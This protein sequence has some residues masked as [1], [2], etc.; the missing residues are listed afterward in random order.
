PL[1]LPEPGPPLH[2]QGRSIAGAARVQRSAQGPPARRAGRGRGA[3]DP[4]A[5]ELTRAARWKMQGAGVRIY[6]SEHLQCLRRSE[7]ENSNPPLPCCP[8]SC[9]LTARRSDGFKLRSTRAS[10]ENQ[11]RCNEL[12]RNAA[13]CQEPCGARLTAA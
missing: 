9:I 10:A 12:L 6:E 8:P 4:L 11:L 5:D 7:R 2:G 1:P 13:R 3:D